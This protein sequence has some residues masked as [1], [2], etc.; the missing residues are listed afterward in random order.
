MPNRFLPYNPLKTPLVLFFL[1]PTK[2]T[3]IKTQPHY[4]VFPLIESFGV[5]NLMLRET[6]RFIMVLP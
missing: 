3:P 6:Q 2:L 1:K 5:L 4:H